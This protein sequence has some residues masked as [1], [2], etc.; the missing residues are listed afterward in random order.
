MLQIAEISFR[1]SAALGLQVAPSSPFS[2]HKKEYEN[3]REKSGSSYAAC[4]FHF[5]NDLGS[6]IVAINSSKKKNFT[7][8]S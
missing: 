1:Q 8:S 4:W 3:S 6:F 7:D 2:M 5:P